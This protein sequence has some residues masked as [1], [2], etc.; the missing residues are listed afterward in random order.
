LNYRDR[1]KSFEELG[2]PDPELDQKQAI[3]KTL[4]WI[5]QIKFD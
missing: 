4:Q 2:L 5:K 3:N 1:V